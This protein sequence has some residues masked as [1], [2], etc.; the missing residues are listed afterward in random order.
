M[1]NAPKHVSV[2]QRSK[3]S[4]IYWNCQLSCCT[5]FDWWHR[6]TGCAEMTPPSCSSRRGWRVAAPAGPH[7]FLLPGCQQA[8]QRRLAAGRCPASALP[9]ESQ[10]DVV[11]L[12]LLHCKMPGTTFKSGHSLDGCLRRTAA[13]A[14]AHLGRHLLSHADGNRAN[15]TKGIHSPASA[16]PAAA[17]PGTCVHLLTCW[18]RRP[19]SPPARAA[20]NLCKRTSA[21]QPDGS[22]TCCIWRLNQHVD[23]RD[24]DF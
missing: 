8:S 11:R 15:M 17:S 5:D 7:P 13:P 16:I 20:G 18:R 21:L 24:D 1:P 14:V 22:L 23:Q 12:S 2:L 6:A 4:T 19:R 9:A 3:R 10:T